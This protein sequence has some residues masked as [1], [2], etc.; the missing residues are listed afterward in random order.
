MSRLSSDTVI[1]TIG[2][3]RPGIGAT[4]PLVSSSGDVS[5]RARPVTRRIRNRAPA[6][7][8]DAFW[9]PANPAGC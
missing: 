9:L 6:A 3:L 7:P 5:W 1:A 8:L 2:F 4:V